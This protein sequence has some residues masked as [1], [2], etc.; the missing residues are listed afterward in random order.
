MFPQFEGPDGSLPAVN[1][2]GE[3]HFAHAPQMTI[4]AFL[5]LL[6]TS[7]VQQC[8]GKR[9]TL[10]FQINTLQAWSLSV[11]ASQS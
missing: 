1:G 4:G 2:I 7:M 11:L 3:H 8:I 5:I 9:K 10:Q 6:S